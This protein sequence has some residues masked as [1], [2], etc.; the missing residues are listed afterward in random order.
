MK[1][2]LLLSII[3]L[4]FNY[5][6][7]QNPTFLGLRQPEITPD[8]QAILQKDHLRGVEIDNM[9]DNDGGSSTLTPEQEEYKASHTFIPQPPEGFVRI[10]K[11]AI[12]VDKSIMKAYGHAMPSFLLKAIAGHEQFNKADPEKREKL[13]ERG[14]FPPGPY[15][16]DMEYIFERKTSEGATFIFGVV[17][18]RCIEKTCSIKDFKCSYTALFSAFEPKDP[19][20]PRRF[21][22]LVVRMPPEGYMQCPNPHVL[23]ELL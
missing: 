17:A 1:A 15:L 20:A 14:F 22:D 18:N 11:S 2:T 5:A 21:L 13:L 23:D 16:I 3:A 19:A 10:P 12:K 8:Q 9:F 6:L 7:G 4:C